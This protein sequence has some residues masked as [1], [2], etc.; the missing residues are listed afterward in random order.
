MPTNITDRINDALF[1]QPQGGLAAGIQLCGGLFLLGFY[2]YYT[3][4][5]TSTVTSAVAIIAAGMSLSGTAEFIPKSRQR[6]A[7]VLRLVSILGLLGFLAV[8]VAAPDTFIS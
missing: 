5:T 7:G 2:T 4:W 1:S 3:I 8:L 6:A